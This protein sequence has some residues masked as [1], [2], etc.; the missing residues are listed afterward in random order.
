MGFVNHE[1]VNAK[2]FKIRRGR[3]MPGSKGGQNLVLSPVGAFVFLVAFGPF[4]RLIMEAHVVEVRLKR[5][6]PETNHL[7]RLKRHENL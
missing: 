6:L 1:R 3:L 7:E 5:F 4:I 2:I